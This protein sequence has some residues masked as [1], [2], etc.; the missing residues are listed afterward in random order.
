M[1]K[2]DF[3]GDFIN[4]AI[5]SCKK[6]SLLRLFVCL[7]FPTDKLCSIAKSKIGITT[8]VFKIN[9]KKVVIKEI[10]DDEKYTYTNILKNQLE[11]IIMI[12]N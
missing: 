9:G 6:T 5:F 1:R 2:W 12:I 10:T 3:E 4:S 11:E 8:N 7:C